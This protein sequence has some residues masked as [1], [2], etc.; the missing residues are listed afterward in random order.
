MGDFTVLNKNTFLIEHIRCLA[1]RDLSSL[2]KSFLR[3][4]FLKNDRHQPW[5]YDR[6]EDT[7][8]ISF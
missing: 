7:N 4:L 2:I 3:L 5:K 6:E 8:L 1:S